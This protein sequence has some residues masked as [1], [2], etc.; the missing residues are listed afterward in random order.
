MPLVYTQVFKPAA[1]VKQPNS[2]QMNLA[3]IALPLVLL[4]GTSFSSDEAKPGSSV[5][6]AFCD[7]LRPVLSGLK[8]NFTNLKGNAMGSRTNFWH[9]TLTLSNT[10]NNYIFTQFD[11]NGKAFSNEY[12]AVLSEKTTPVEQNVAIDQFAKLLDQCPLPGYT[13][14]VKTTGLSQFSDD[15]ALEKNAGKVIKWTNATDK[16]EIELSG[17]FDV[18]TQRHRVA[19]KFKA[20]YNHAVIPSKSA[21]STTAA[22]FTV[23]NSLQEEVLGYWLDFDGKEVYY[24]SLKPKFQI[25]MDSYTG[26]V[27]RFRSASSKN[28]V[29][30]TLIGNAATTLELK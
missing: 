17:Y 30:N 13:K 11:F 25:V 15:P 28:I 20:P 29:K 26:H 8:D 2:I 6:K 10:S 16:T 27:W 14:T 24:F 5:S 23:I 12:Y 22:K 7:E 4:L 9:S 3:A 18:V 21:R 19:A 1:I